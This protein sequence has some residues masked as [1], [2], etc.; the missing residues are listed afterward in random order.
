MFQ[1]SK[2]MNLNIAGMGTDT[3]TC[4]RF[5]HFNV[6]VIGALQHITLQFE[7][8]QHSENNIKRF[9]PTWTSSHLS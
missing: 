3:E 8:S 9:P 7:K 5:A 6:H 2:F 4:I 1:P